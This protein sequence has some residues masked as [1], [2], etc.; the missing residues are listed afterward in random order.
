MPYATGIQAALDLAGTW[1]DISTYLYNRSLPGITITR[2]RPDETSQATPSK[3]TGQLNNRDGR[4]TSR[5][6]AGP[7]YPDLTR[8]TAIRLSVPD[9]G[10]YLRLE[11][12][13]VSYASMP[14]SGVL[15]SGSATLDIRFD[16]ELTDWQ[17]SC[18]AGW[19]AVSERAWCVLLNG[20]GTITFAWTTDGVT[21]Q[22]A[23]ST[24]PLPLGAGCLQV[25]FTGSTGVITFG[26]AATGGISGSFT[27]LGSSVGPGTATTIFASTAA[28]AI[29]YSV[30]ANG[31]F[32]VT[33]IN[34]EVFDCQVRSGIGGSIKAEPAFTS[35]TAGATSWTDAESNT[36]TLA[37]TSE[38]SSRSY[39]YHGEMSS[40]PVA[41]DPSGHDIWVPFQASGILRRLAQGN[42]P[43]LSAIR[44]GITS[45]SGLDLPLAY[46]PGEDLA[47]S[48]QLT[49]GLPG[50]QPMVFSATMPSLASSTVFQ[51]S[52]SLPTF[53][54]SS[55]TGVVPPSTTGAVVLSFLLAVPSGGDTDG[56]TVAQIATT[57]TAANI[58]VIYDSAISGGTLWAAG[59][60]ASNNLLWSTSTSAITNVNGALLLVQMSVR[61]NGSATIYE[62]EALAAGDTTPQTA[63]GGF[64]SS[65]AG[66]AFKVIMN[67]GY[68]GG[69]LSGSACGHIFAQGFHAD[70]SALAQQLNA[71]A[72]ETAAT[73]FARLCAEN[74]IA[75]RI[76]GYPGAS[77]LMGGQTID[78]LNNVL[79]ACEDADNGMI[80]EPRQ[81][82]GLGYRT[83]NSMCSQTPALTLNYSADQVGD[84]ESSPVSLTSIDDDQ[85][86]RNDVTVTREAGQQQGSSYEYA[87][88][89]GSPMS[90]SPPPVG[91]G[92]YTN[93][94]SLNLD[95]DRQLPSAAMWLVHV[96][97]VEGERYPQVT[98]GLH[99]PVIIADG[100]GFA[101]QDVNIG[102]YVKI[103]NPPAWL[104]PDPIRQVVAGVTETMTSYLFQV[105]WNAIPESPY[106]VFVAGDAVFGRA[107]TSGSTLSS[108]VSSSATSLSVATATGYRLW[109][110]SGSDFP[111]NIEIAGEEM[112]VTNIT[113]TSSPQTFTVTRSVNGVVKS[114]A[115]GAAAGLYQS[116]VLALA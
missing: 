32:G 101:I 90:I 24:Q 39:R 70:L 93:A 79:Q 85:Y 36:W 2:G 5:N 38:L 42:A 86:T 60:D 69:S 112:T 108:G 83:L 40:L 10:T 114:Q 91:V 109:T 49:S 27:Q 72:G 35:Q 59:A 34:G 31:D 22:T 75:S 46:W 4:F 89:D 37:G 17:P 71:W 20:D 66:S 106:E 68:T 99:R 76:Y 87:L 21:I 43:I 84:Q 16:M 47:G 48:Q 116:V 102:D 96:G 107:D 57:G 9:S 55:W 65:S 33:G 29:G 77:V 67:S 51:C 19:W 74:N 25:T 111:F 52:N 82:F 62:I 54:G 104:P 30:Q 13:S 3:M 105:A 28:F 44:R 80:Y 6:P 12:D 45:L 58:A 50:G 81:A 15:P 110:V 113:G 63:S 103:T 1:T 18:I 73:R 92:D 64:A 97:T 11:N 56:A 7:Y 95:G 98:T 78:T 115:S 94:V 41:W 23:Q 100:L 8:N 88:N 53:S 26:T 14:A 61:N